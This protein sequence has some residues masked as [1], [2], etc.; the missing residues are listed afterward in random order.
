ME[1]EKIVFADAIELAKF[2]KEINSRIVEEQGLIRRAKK[3]ID[4]Y[5]TFCLDARGPLETLYDID[6][7]ESKS[8]IKQYVKHIEWHR[9]NKLKGQ[10]VYLATKR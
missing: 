2:I 4:K 6:D 9:D 10:I 5:P 3:H 1:H 7:K 8:L